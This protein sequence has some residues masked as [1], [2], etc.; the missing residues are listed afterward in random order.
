MQLFIV[1]A[2]TTEL[3][4]GNQAGV[5]IVPAGQAFPEDGVMQQIARELKHSETAFVQDA[6]NG[7]FTLRYF[8]PEGEVPLCGHATISAFTV[9]CE[10]KA[11]KSGTYTAQTR[12]GD[13]NVT[14]EPDKIWLEM[15]RAEVIRQ[16]AH[17]ES[18]RVYAAF[19]MSS[20]EQPD[21]MP[22]CI[23]KAGL[24]DILLPVNSKTSLDGAKL[25]RDLM[26][27]LSRELDVVGAHLFYCPPD[28]RPGAHCRNFAPLYGI[29]E[30]SAT[31]T[32]NAA[33]THYLRL[34]GKIS[35]DAVNTFIQGE[36]MGK[37]S[38]I[39]SRIDDG[40]TIRIG[41]GAVISVKGTLNL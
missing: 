30:E 7:V 5:V 16:L 22:P 36:G 40:G 32:S 12:S 39:Q 28:G 14:V 4:G 34:R 38:V 11:L 33:L 3:F 9:L 21:D 35:P 25:N 17:E 29:D 18:A 26:I 27:E 24:M 19:G 8:T 20:S 37:P 13:L 31:G 23:A 6:G 15:P 10:E 41:G 1:D 2:F